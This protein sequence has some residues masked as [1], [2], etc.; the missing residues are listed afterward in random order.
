MRRQLAEP[1]PAHIPLGCPAKRK[2]FSLAHTKAQRAGGKRKKNMKMFCAERESFSGFMFSVSF[3]KY[4]EVDDTGRGY[5]E[6]ASKEKASGQLF[7]R[8]VFCAIGL[9]LWERTLIL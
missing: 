4:E 8:V 7:R 2:I 3:S 9:G 6:R 1:T 5:G